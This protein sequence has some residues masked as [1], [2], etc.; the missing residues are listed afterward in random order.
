MLKEFNALLLTIQIYNCYMLPFIYHNL[1]IDR[2]LAH[3]MTETL[4]FF[5]AKMLKHVTE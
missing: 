4:M 5:L 3:M 1:N 2:L